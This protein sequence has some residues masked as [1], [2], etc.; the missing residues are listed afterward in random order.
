M[1]LVIRPIVNN[2]IAL[3]LTGLYAFAQWTIQNPLP[4]IN[5][6][7]S[8]YFPDA[9]T[10]YVVGDHG[11]ILKTTNGGGPAVGINE[12]PLQTNNSLNSLKIYP[13]P[14]TEKITIQSSEAGSNMNGT[15]FIYGMAG[16]ELIKQQVNGSKTEIMVNSLPAG[17][18][19]IRLVN[20]KK[21]EFGK[22]VKE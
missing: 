7:N 2:S 15:V 19:F 17:I 8:V 21:I 6:L 13:N 5:P 1:S 18:Y 12:P 16:P 10:G 22:F 14:A 4:T 11:T 9:N 20:N 3:F